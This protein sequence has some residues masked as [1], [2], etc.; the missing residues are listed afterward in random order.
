MD[1]GALSGASYAAV[2]LPRNSVGS[3]QIRDNAV[4][5]SKVRNGSLRAEDFMAG[6][7]PRGERGERGETGER[8]PAGAQG[9]R[10]EAGPQGAAGPQGLRGPSDLFW[11]QGDQENVLAASATYYTVASMSL[12]PGDY[13]LTGMLTVKANFTGS[14]VNPPGG[15]EW[16]VDCHLWPSVGDSTPALAGSRLPR[17]AGDRDFIPMSLDGALERSRESA[18]VLVRLRCAKVTNPGT[19]ALELSAVYPTLTAIRVATSTPGPN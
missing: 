11:T 12:P 15:T 17:V 6:Q 16:A 4:V 1:F 14:Y 13:K 10:G 2:Q 18:D 19:S 8:G 5:S 3:K 7:L 9:D